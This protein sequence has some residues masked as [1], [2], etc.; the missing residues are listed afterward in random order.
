MYTQRFFNVFFLKK[1]QYSGNQRKGGGE[2]D[3]LKKMDGVIDIV[4]TQKP[5]N[6]FAG[7]RRNLGKKP[8]GIT[9]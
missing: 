5:A 9:I 3:I 2:F 8:F 4:G 6:K 1:T 7:Y